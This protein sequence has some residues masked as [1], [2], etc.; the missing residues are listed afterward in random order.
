MI[1]VVYRFVAVRSTIEHQQQRQKL[2]SFGGYSFFRVSKT[3][4][5]DKQGLGL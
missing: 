3:R 1:K 2:S 5:K 4:C